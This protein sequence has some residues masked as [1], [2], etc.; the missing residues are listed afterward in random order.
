MIPKR[1]SGVLSQWHG[2]FTVRK[3]IVDA[4]H[5]D[6]AAEDFPGILQGRIAA[7]SKAEE[8]Q[9]DERC[10]QIQNCNVFQVQWLFVLHKKYPLY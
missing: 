6:E 8:E 1:R 9:E 2:L 5:G 4:D 3:G 10:D 7:D